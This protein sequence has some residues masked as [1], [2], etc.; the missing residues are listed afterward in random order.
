METIKGWSQRYASRCYSKLNTN[1]AHAK[2]VLAKKCED[3]GKPMPAYI[4]ELI[5]LASLT[6]EKGIER[7]LCSLI[8]VFNEKGNV[9]LVEIVGVLQTPA[10]KELKTAYKATRLAMWSEALIQTLINDN[11]ID[12]IEDGHQ[13]ENFKPKYK[14]VWIKGKPVEVQ[15]NK[16]TVASV[17]LKLSCVEGDDLYY[18]TAPS[19]EPEESRHVLGSVWCKGFNEI[20]ACDEVLSLT[21]ATPLKFNQ[22][23]WSAMDEMIEV[24]LDPADCPLNKSW[25]EYCEEREI[26][27]AQYYQHINDYINVS[28]ILGEVFYNTYE[29]D[30]RGRLYA[31]NDVGNFIGIKPIRAMVQPAQGVVVTKEDVKELEDLF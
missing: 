25:K 29:P 20:D 4:D 24:V 17:V 7:I 27:Y 2:Q 9:S 18:V 3:A 8:H 11:V 30:Y 23:I 21:N 6:G 12:I 31:N 22:N 19:A 1:L 26:A 10:I 14:T 13:I 15:A 16:S 28:G 5:Q